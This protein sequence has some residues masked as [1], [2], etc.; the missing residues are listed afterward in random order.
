[1]MTRS[2]VLICTLALF[3]SAA[4]PSAYPQEVRSLVISGGQVMI[5]GRT[6]AHENL[7]S[8][9]DVSGREESYR[10]I[11]DGSPVIEINGVLY[12]LAD[13]T[14]EVI[15]NVDAAESSIPA[16][17]RPDVFGAQ[18]SAPQSFDLIDGIAPV[19]R[20][21]ILPYEPY[22]RFNGL[23]FNALEQKAHQLYQPSEEMARRRIR[24]ADM[25]QRLASHARQMQEAVLQ[26]PQIE[27]Q[28]YL[29]EVRRQDHELFDQIMLEAEMEA[30][31]HELASRIRTLSPNEDRTAL[32][33]ELRSK[34]ET[35]FDLKQENRKREIVQ[36][37]GQ[38]E[39]LQ[40]RLALRQEKKQQIIED[41]MR[42]LIGQ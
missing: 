35:I 30:M 21:Q 31:T 37:Q 15:G 23:K 32:L 28:Q 3:Q 8:A 18:L 27:V 17:F 6:V 13:N 20:G 12:R 9:L 33:T 39:E 16:F 26:L 11:G 7:P 25:A 36:L 2:L 1:M 40:K 29:G 4:P 22:S 42:E 5:D 24:N 38:L 34:L 14:L 41:R 19:Q 10:F